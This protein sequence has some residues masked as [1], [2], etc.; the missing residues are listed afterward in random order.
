M[1]ASKGAPAEENTVSIPEASAISRLVKCVS[2][3][4]SGSDLGEILR[5]PRVGEEIYIRDVDF[6][7]IAED[8]VDE[9]ASDEAAASCDEN[10]HGF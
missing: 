5:V 1:I 2:I 3:G 6:R 8:V 9:V 10:F 7:V 4:V